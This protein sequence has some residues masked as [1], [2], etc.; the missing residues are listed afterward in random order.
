[1]RPE[2][3]PKLTPDP[4]KQKYA[5]TAVST[6][7]VP[8]CVLFLGRGKRFYTAWVNRYRAPAAVSALKSAF[9][10]KT[11]LIPVPSLVIGGINGLVPA[12]SGFGE[13]DR[14]KLEPD[15]ASP[16]EVDAVAEGEFDAESAA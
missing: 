4:I 3:A 7:I 15:S 10:A 2:L 16:S 14:I 11:D 9:T 5:Q 12:S 13:N 8:G 6:R 1:V